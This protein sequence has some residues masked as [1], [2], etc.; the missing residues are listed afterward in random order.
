MDAI[1]YAIFLDELVK[2][3]DK[4]DAPTQATIG[5][6]P[7]APAED[8]DLAQKYGLVPNRGWKVSAEVIDR[9]RS[10]VSAYYGFKID[11]IQPVCIVDPKDPLHG[12]EFDVLGIRYEVHDTQLT[13]IGEL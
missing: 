11:L 6:E 8:E 1:D 7:K 9:F 3:F 10:K 2:R 5:P 12:C 4:K 13:C